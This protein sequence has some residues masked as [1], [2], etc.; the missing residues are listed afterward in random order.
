MS[1]VSSRRVPVVCG[2]AL[3]R[4]RSVCFLLCRS[5]LVGL[6]TERRKGFST[7]AMNWNELPSGSRVWVLYCPNVKQWHESAS[8]KPR[9]LKAGII[10]TVD[11][12]IYEE[13][14]SELEE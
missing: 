5:L 11:G 2:V 13:I 7:L 4:D 14:F 3:C 12:D 9:I 1:H 10:A 8:C 6:L